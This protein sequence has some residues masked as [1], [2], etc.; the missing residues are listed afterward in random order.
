MA[1]E[2][3]E[4]DTNLF[5]NDRKQE[6]WHADFNGKILVNGNYYY[7]N[8]MDKREDPESKV[9]FRLQLRQ[10]GEPRQA[11]KASGFDSDDLG[12]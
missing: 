10:V 12:L 1:Y 2:I 7:V 11:P 8:L 4:L 9:S 6:S 3:R 5:P